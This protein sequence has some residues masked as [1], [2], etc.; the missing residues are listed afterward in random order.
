MNHP[1]SYKGY[2]LFQSSYQQDRDPQTSEI[3]REATILSVSKDPGENLVFAGYTFL[4][5]GM[6]VVL[7]TRMVEARKRAEL[8]RLLSETTPAAPARR[9]APGRP[10]PRWRSPCS[11]P[12]APRRR[13]APDGWAKVDAIRR[14]PVQ[15]DGRSMPFDTLAREAVWNV[16]GKY[17]WNGEDPVV[18]VAQWLF[19]PMR[20]ANTPLVELGSPE[21]AVAVGLPSGTKYASFS[22]L[23]SSQRVL[24]IMQQ[25]RQ[26]AMSD[27]PRRGVLAQ[28]EKLEERLVWMQGFLEKDKLRAIPVAGKPAARWGV[29]Q[30]MAAST[31][32]SRSRRARASRAGRRRRRS[33][34]RSS[35]RRSARRA[36][37][38]SC[39]LGALV[40]SLVAW[41]R[42]SKLLDGLAFARPPRRV[43][44]DDLGHRDALDGRG[45]HPGLQHVRVAALPRLGRRALRGGGARRSSRNRLVVLNANAMAALT[46]ALTDLLPID[47]FI[48]PM[49][50]VLS[51]T[52][53]LAIHV[54]IIMVGYS[55]LALG[56][57]IAHMQI[58]FTI[59]AP[60]RDGP[61]EPHGG[62]ELL[63]HAGRVDP[64]HRR[65]PHRLGLGGVVV[66]PLLGLGSE[67]GLVARRV[68]RVHGD[69]PRQVR[70]AHRPVRRGGAVG[71]VAF[72]TILMTY[73]GVNYVLGTGLHSYGMG[74]SPVVNWMMSS[75]S[76]RRRSSAGA[77]TRTRSGSARPPRSRPDP[78]AASR[79]TKGRPGCSGS[80]LSAFS[81]ARGVPAAK[82]QRPVT[83]GG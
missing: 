78:R 14:L 61:H 56:V 40:V 79:D 68:P 23:V 33:T 70:Q 46:M 15:H 49:P 66:G 81:G 3:R 50:P 54:P 18:T 27:Q 60:R 32:S 9:A 44:G 42:K 35:T 2:T 34:A 28:A 45:P 36:S 53:W 48:H 38:G 5:L 59:F 19:D 74:D 71:I 26:A 1:F 73:L 58:G 72:Q 77:G 13:R 24:G 67:G 16:T 57:V 83:L 65:H 31:T 21:L 25:A 82:K 30:P 80:A 43:R 75:R 69:H 7:G 37:P 29:P 64:A 10:R 22:Q 4:V 6:I 39:S 41:S 8:E 11:P 76:P 52:P 47:R 62:P 55:V 63:V 51:G 17:S 20:A 12:P